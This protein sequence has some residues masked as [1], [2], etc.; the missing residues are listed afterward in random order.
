MNTLVDTETSTPQ[1][2]SRRFALFIPIS[3]STNTE[4]A[5]EVSST[6]TRSPRGVLLIVFSVGGGTG[7][8]DL[9]TNTGDPFE[10]ILNRLF[11]SHQPSGAPPAS[12]KAIDSLKPIIVDAK[13]KQESIKC[14]VCCEEFEIDAENT[15]D[16]VELPCLHV[17]HRDC[18]TPWLK[19]H[20]TCCLC[21]QEL[22][23]EEKASDESLNSTSTASDEIPPLVSENE[24]NQGSNT[25]SSEGDILEQPSTRDLEMEAL[26]IAQFLSLLRS[27]PH[28]TNSEMDVDGSI[29]T[30]TSTPIVPTPSPLT[31]PTID[32]DND[33]TQPPDNGGKI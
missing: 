27:Q 17:Y 7:P 2:R 24:T 12:Q 28:D 4:V 11:L 10:S 18:I 8:A 22:S 31:N 19:Q 26:S 14:C 21:R 13:V 30:S 1:S 6:S 3:R 9:N 25:T 20:G 16:V 29:S 5:T 32:A 15:N 33:S 23:P